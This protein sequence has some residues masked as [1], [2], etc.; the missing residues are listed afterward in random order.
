MTAHSKNCNL[1]LR[2]KLAPKQCSTSVPTLLDCFQY[3][4]A[5]PNLEHFRCRL[6]S[7]DLSNHSGCHLLP[8]RIRLVGPAP[9]QEL[10]GFVQAP[11]PSC[12][13]LPGRRRNNHQG[14][15]IVQLKKKVKRTSTSAFVH[16]NGLEVRFMMVR[17][18]SSSVQQQGIYQNLNVGQRASIG[19][20][21]SGWNNVQGT[22]RQYVCRY[23]C[24]KP[25]KP[26]F[27]CTGRCTKLWHVD[28]PAQPGMLLSA[29]TECAYESQETLE[30]RPIGNKHCRVGM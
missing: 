29:G 28:G 7:P 18:Q 13:V 3:S 21:L 10:Q 22:H 4:D 2:L 30:A 14:Q 16:R 26:C 17:V 1:H 9:M 15:F 20:L 12:T 8:L 19:L 23:F 27:R 11:Q 25:R 6:V 24:C 5:S